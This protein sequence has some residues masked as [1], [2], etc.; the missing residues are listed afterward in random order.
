VFGLCAARAGAGA[1]PLTRALAACGQRSLSC[2]LG[3]S[4]LFVA[5][6]PA[7]TLNLGARLGVAQAAVL[8]V[9]VWLVLL[10]VAVVS[11]RAGYRGPAEVLLRR[12]TYGWRPHRGAPA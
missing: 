7:W 8:A 4:V 11:A 5:L 1:G 10:L 3:Q 6:L 9:V 2:Y 12:L